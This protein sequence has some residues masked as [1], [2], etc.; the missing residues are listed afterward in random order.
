MRL[1]FINATPFRNPGKMRL[2]V[3]HC[4]PPFIVLITIP[5]A[6]TAM[7]VLLLRNETE[8]RFSVVPLIEDCQVPP[9]FVVL[10]IIPPSPT[11]KPVR[12]SGNSDAFNLLMGP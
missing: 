4:I 2:G 5:D 9:A 10:R 11:R 1:L 8:N 6:P 12:D 7:P 3:R